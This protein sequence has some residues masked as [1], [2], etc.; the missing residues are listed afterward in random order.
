MGDRIPVS[1][2]VSGLSRL[3]GD[4]LEGLLELARSADDLG[5]DQLVVT[6]H[7]AIGPRTDRYPYG[8]FPF[9]DDEPWPEPLTTLA[10][11]AGA[12]R[13]VRLGTGVLI[14]PLRPPLLLA[15]TLATLDVLSGGRLDLGVGTG[16][17]REEFDGA[18]VPFAERAA[19]LD[20]TLRACKVLWTQSPASF[21]SA[22][23]S[24]R[25]LVCLPQPA[26][27]GGVPV[28]FGVRLTD[29]NLQ[30]IVELGD[31]WMPLV[32]EDELFAGAERLRT[33]FREAGRDPDGLGI[34]APIAPAKSPGR[35]DPAHVRNELDRLRDRGATLA[36][37][38][39][40]QYARHPDDVRPFL[41]AL[42]RARHA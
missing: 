18:G 42:A 38:A 13:R 14:A 6:D 26:Q 17:Q 7:L 22:T 35:L 2:I 4:R 15:K 25:D 23:V 29:A 5:I 28:W 31:G 32:P 12:T 10:V 34:R 20:D 41:E 11:L 9:G 21:A 1:V 33:A 8:A 3:M 40:A 16:W 30:R 24:F 36:S 37:L 19:R 27:P 39:L